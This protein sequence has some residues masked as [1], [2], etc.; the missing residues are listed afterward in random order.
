MAVRRP[1]RLAGLVA[2]ATCF[3]TLASAQV[4]GA[5]V[6]QNAFS[7][8][9]LSVAA[10]LASGRGQSFYGAAAAWGMG[11]SGSEG[12]LSLSAAAGAQR[13]N[14][15][16]RGAYG[17]RVAARIWGSDGGGLGV[18]GFAGYGGAPR[19]KTGSVVTNPAIMS[20]PVGVSVGYR[21]ALG[22]TRGLSA[23]VSPFY[24]W[25]RTDSDSVASSSS[26]RASAGI[27][28][29][30]TS[31]FGVTIG[32]ELGG[33]RAA[34]TGTRAASSGTFGAAVSFVPGGRR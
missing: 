30:F 25:D 31:A 16:T 19:T 6:L 9:G 3:G 2:A 10:N 24:R 28:F 17:A 11:G 23:Y 13:A 29:S 14:E 18:A 27:D 21:R 4:P 15:A 20:V 5:P 7:N 32:G 22:R 12:R 34:T 1:A 8:R 33:G 26:F